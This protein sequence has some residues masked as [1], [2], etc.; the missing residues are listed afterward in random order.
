MTAASIYHGGKFFLNTEVFKQ[1]RKKSVQHKYIWHMHQIVPM[2]G[3]ITAGLFFVC[4]I[5]LTRF[6]MCFFTYR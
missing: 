5:C 6:F 2:Q 3:R 4:N 1:L